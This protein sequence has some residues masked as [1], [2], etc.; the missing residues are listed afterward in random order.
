MEY[1]QLL[2]YRP[3]WDHIIQVHQYVFFFLFILDVIA[4]INVL[5]NDILNF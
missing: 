2:N 3:G 1:C 4:Q 5:V